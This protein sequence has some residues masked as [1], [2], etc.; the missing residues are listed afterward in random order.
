MGQGVVGGCNSKNRAVEGGHG[1][2]TQ[3]GLAAAW[4][5]QE[6]GGR[7]GEHPAQRGRVRPVEKAVNAT[8]RGLDCILGPGSQVS[9][10][11]R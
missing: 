3:R 1:P 6:M 8:S 2:G 5:L 7:E 4:C 10:T 9:S 11:L